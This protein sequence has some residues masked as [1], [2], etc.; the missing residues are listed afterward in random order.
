LSNFQIN[1]TP[2][3]IYS[4]YIKKMK[5]RITKKI[6]IEIMKRNLKNHPDLPANFSLESLRDQ[7]PFRVPDGYFDELP[8]RIN[9]RIEAN[10]I[11]TKSRRMHPGVFAAAAS[12]VVLLGLAL[13]MRTS[14]FTS[15]S[16]SSEMQLAAITDTHIV[17][18]LGTKIMTGE[19]D[20]ST[21]MEAVVNAD[22]DASTTASTSKTTVQTESTRIL[23]SVSDAEII[24]Y[25]VQNQTPSNTASDISQQ[26]D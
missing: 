21:L 24:E 4:E 13:V 18:H 8:H 6:N 2:E 23:P 17:S 7:N 26:N 12:V 1:D 10:P 3:R 11:N 9:A 16:T 22:S 14:I 15:N 19:I 25:L 20:E 5:S